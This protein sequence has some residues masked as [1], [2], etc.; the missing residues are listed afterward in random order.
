V[1]G[2]KDE[3]LILKKQTYAKTEAYKLF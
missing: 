3:N 2:L 1:S